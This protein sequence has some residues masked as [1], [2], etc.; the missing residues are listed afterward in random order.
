V[1]GWASFAEG[2]SHGCQLRVPGIWQLASGKGTAGGERA[3]ARRAG[4]PGLAA[5]AECY[6]VAPFLAAVPFT[7]P[8][9][10]LVAS[11]QLSVN[12]RWEMSSCSAKS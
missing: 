10:G 8:S 11:S 1:T 7:A 12:F 4:I 2:N 5:H 6:L 9:S 3:S